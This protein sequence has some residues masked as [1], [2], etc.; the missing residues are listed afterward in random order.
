MTYEDGAIA[1]PTGP[2]LGIEVDRGKLAEF[3]ERYRAEGGYQYDRDP[4]RPGWFAMMPEKRFANPAVKEAPA[5]YAHA[6][7]GRA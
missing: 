4:A 6:G 3:A 1:V 2:G 5:I 7:N